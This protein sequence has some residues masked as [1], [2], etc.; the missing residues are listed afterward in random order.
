M[1]NY[2][3]VRFNLRGLS[4][5]AL[6]LV[7][8]QAASGEN[9]VSIRGNASAAAAVRDEPCPTCAQAIGLD[10]FRA[11]VG[12]EITPVIIELQD[13]PG[14]RRRMAAEKAG[15]AMTVKDLMG[16]GATLQARQKGFIASLPTSGVRALLRE[17]ATRQIAG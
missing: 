14:L 15:R 16:H 1:R 12:G 13:S 2:S 11:S 3:L 17:T 4:V 6:V 9:S 10:A 5:G 8:S 7:L